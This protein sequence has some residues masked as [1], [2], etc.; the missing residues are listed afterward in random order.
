MQ[1]RLC[2]LVVSVLL[3][4]MCIRRSCVVFMLPVPQGRVWSRVK[5]IAWLC[6]VHAGVGVVVVSV[7]LAHLAKEDLG[8]V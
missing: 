7:L 3:A 5:I 6:G 4:G 1:F 2:V 8:W